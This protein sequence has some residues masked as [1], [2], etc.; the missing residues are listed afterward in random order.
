MNDHGSRGNR[1]LAGRPF[2]QDT[3]GARRLAYLETLRGLAALAVVFS[4]IFATANLHGWAAGLALAAINSPLSVLIN[5]R[6]AVIFFFTLSGYVLT[7][8]ALETND[9]RMIFRGAVK[10]WPRLAGPVLASTPMSWA[11]W[12]FGLYFH[13]E[14]S[15]FAAND[16]LVHFA[17][18]TPDLQ[19][20]PDMR[21][22]AAVQQGVW[23][24]FVHGD[25]SFNSNL[26]TMS[27]EFAGSFAIFIA[28]AL[29]S[30]FRSRIIPRVGIIL[31]AI[32]GAMSYGDL[33][34]VPFGIGLGLA[35]L[36]AAGRASASPTMAIALVVGA[37]Y[38]FGYRGGTTMYTWLPS[39]NPETGTMTV[40][41]AVA[42]GALI[43]GITRWPRARAGLTGRFGR[44]LGSLSFPIYLV[45]LP[46]ILSAGCATM[47]A[48]QPRNGGNVASAAMA[49]VSLAGTA[50]AAWV[51]WIADRQWVASLNRLVGR[52]PMFSQ[53]L[54]SLSAWRPSDGSNPFD[55]LKR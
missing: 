3:I 25:D 12:H 23:S 28:A 35:S 34:Y 38:T 52:A 46:V 10:R 37:T 13:V 32:F 14:A 11:L 5:G 44:L 33:L 39:F 2:R 18:G 19:N 1:V 48:L 41:F 16:W 20:L 43:S 51:L 47:V 26:W 30:L 53:P 42:S 4:H 6:G 36:H 29:I 40:A 54:P 24:T 15:K 22:I 17:Y 49:G 21:L 27:Y 50:A 7:L 45:H 8:R 9:T 31:F 55:H